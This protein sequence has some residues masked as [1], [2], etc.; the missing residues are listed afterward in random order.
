MDNYRDLLAPGGCML[1]H[2]CGFGAHNGLPDTHPGVR[3]VIDEC[4]MTAP[5]FRP[6]LLA[7]TQ[8]AFLKESG[9]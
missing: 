4:V 9:T 5:E 1:F 8:F 7:H 2:D 6:L 3:K